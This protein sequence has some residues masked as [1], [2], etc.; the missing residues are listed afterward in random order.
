MTLKSGKAVNKVVNKA[1]N[2]VVSSTDL[3][4]TDLSGTD[5]SSS[6]ARPVLKLTEQNPYTML[7]VGHRRYVEARLQGLTIMA[8]QRAAG[9]K[10]PNNSLERNPK[11]RAAIKYLL[12]ESTRSVTELTKTDVMTGMLDAVNAASTAAEL[13]MAWREMGKLI[14]AYEPE[15]KILEIHEYSA[16][17]LRTLSD[18]E[19]ARLAGKRMQEAVT[20]DAEFEEV[21]SVMADEFED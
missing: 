15:R 19:L 8:A 12:R 11:V 10:R 3:S 17:D 1:V 20:V 5:L 18:A 14:G 2:K 7:S 16:D 9:I 4:G 13:V 6:S 21:S